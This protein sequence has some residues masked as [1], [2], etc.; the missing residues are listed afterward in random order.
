MFENVVLTPSA[1]AKHW[2]RVF[3][4]TKPKPRFKNPDPLPSRRSQ[5]LEEARKLMSTLW[6]KR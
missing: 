4:E 3:E 2:K 5:N 1:L 6:G